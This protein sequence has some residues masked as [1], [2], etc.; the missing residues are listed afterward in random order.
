MGTRF[1]F[2][3]VHARGAQARAAAEAAAEEVLRLHALWSAHEPSSVV[4][5]INRGAGARAVRV[6][7]DT[8][9]LLLLCREVFRASG[10]AFDI[11]LGGLMR[12]HGFRGAGAGAGGAALPPFGSVHL[13]LDEGSRSVA[14]SGAIELDL[15][16]VAKGWALD[17][18]GAVLREAGV[19]HGLLHAGTS[20]VLA[21]GGAPDGG[22]WRVRVSPAPGAPV[23][24]LRDNALSVSAPHGRVVVRGAEGGA[25]DG[26]A[27]ASIPAHL[28]H[29]LDPGTG[30]PTAPLLHAATVASRAA[31]ADAWSTALLVR[32][33]ALAAVTGVRFI[34]QGRDGSWSAGGV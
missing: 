17:A 13:H 6:D 14:F 2:A 23:V 24:G 19:A 18:A 22:L 4:A 7:H 30:L 26:D 31:V 5:A 3:V 34:T 9:A 1:E 10:G 33:G 20:S 8:F 28:S 27:L 12:A 15:G 21:I 29:T 25:G 32:G 11:A 16:A